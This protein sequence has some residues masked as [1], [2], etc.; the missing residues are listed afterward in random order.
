MAVRQKF[1][2]QRAI[3][4]LRETEQFEPPADLAP[5]AARLAVA[6]E[7]NVTLQKRMRGHFDPARFSVSL[8]PQSATS[9]RFSLAHELGHIAL[10]HGGGCSYVGEPSLADVEL[11]LAEADTGLDHE[12]EADDFAGRLLVPRAWL[13]AEIALKGLPELAATFNV[14][15]AVVLIAA[16][17]YR[18]FARLRS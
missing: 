12:T 15:A 2:E 5:V 6:V 8:A 17:R 18:L 13:R 10:D 9:E 7:R 16:Q 4:L 14:S 11:D 3:E 1:I